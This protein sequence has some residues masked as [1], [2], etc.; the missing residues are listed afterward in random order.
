MA[1]LSLTTPILRG[2]SA[3]GRFLLAVFPSL[4][5]AQEPPA[6][7]GTSTAAESLQP[8][9]FQPVIDDPMLQPAPRPP[10]EIASWQEA[11]ALMFERSTEL[12]SAEAG[13]LRAEGLWRQSLSSLLP[14]VRATAGVA[15]DLLNPDSPP[16][17]GA[18]AGAALSGS[19]GNDPTV[20]VG[21]AAVT[22][23]QSI[24][25]LSAW[26]GL[27]GAEASER[28]AESNLD[29]VR[30]RVTQTL[31]RTLVAVV[32]A[33]RA[34]EINRL[35]L[36]QALERAALTER[37]FELGAAARLDLVRV[38]QDVAVARSALIS[39][40]EQ[41]RRTREAL[42]LAL[43]LD[44]EAGVSRDFNLEG[45][46]AETRAQCRPLGEGELRQDVASAREQAE[47]AAE[48]RKQASAGYLPSLGLT[49][50]LFGYTTD[51]GPGRLATWSIA[52]VLSIPL[53]EGGLRAGLVRERAGLEA[54]ARESAEALRRSVQLEIARTR[55]GEEVARLL[56]ESAASARE[57]AETTDRM[58]R[59]S[60]EI[61][62]ASSLEL[63]QSAVVSR[64]AELSLVLRELEWVQARL[65][66]FLTEA[67][68]EG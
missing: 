17:A 32:A 41:L 7:T 21:T 1:A 38:R 65:D 31:A 56:L 36:R 9:R 33:E 2:L 14:N 55:R 3:L 47:A 48:R 62:R 5:W 10:R 43:G 20:P 4:A 39:G 63:V 51:P 35:G 26:R 30:R 61:G 12:R 45:L 52:A 49:S 11:R 58:T 6:P 37:T 23:N 16:I 34:A 53:W 66:A 27:D 28:S 54:Q 22:L 46:L 40:D 64:Q 8:Q 60:F 29:D 13:L 67:R 15:Y 18:G 24:V 50:N 42:A 59:R 19:S 25:D 68:C 44:V 57:L